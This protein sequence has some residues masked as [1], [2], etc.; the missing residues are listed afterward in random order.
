LR[1]SL[2]YR[3]W[4]EG[5][6]LW[7]F[8]RGV[9]RGSF[10]QSG[11]DRFLLDYFGE[12][13]GTYVDL[14]ANHPYVLSNTYLLY[15]RGWHGMTVEPLSH[16]VRQHRFWRPRDLC[17]HAGVGEKNGVLDF[18]E[19]CYAALSTFDRDRAEQLIRNGAVL[20]HVHQVQMLS[21]ASLCHRVSE[22]LGGMDLL[23]I[24]I[25]GMDG[26]ILRDENWQFL[27]PRLIIYEEPA[28]QTEKDALEAYL[29]SRNYHSIMQSEYNRVCERRG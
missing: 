19:F 11:E 25:E 1:R 27:K 13:R 10:A 18:Y 5:L 8:A 12:R 6:D 22:E 7:S 14:G 20:R 26:L 21:M 16:A 17:I 2:P 3:L 4:H 28:G 24:D 29:L 15:R 9:R 23:S